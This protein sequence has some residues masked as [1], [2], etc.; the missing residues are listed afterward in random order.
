MKT[1]LSSLALFGFLTSAYAHH[2]FGYHFDAEKEVTIAGT[3]REFKFIN[4]HAQVL[5]D[6]TGEDG[7]TETWTCE[8]RGANGLARTGW[9]E[10]TFLP[11]QALELTG[12]AARRRD[13]ECY[14]DFAVMADG[15][16]I[17]HDDPLGGDLYLASA[18]AAAPTGAASS[19]VP[20]FAGVWGQ[21]PGMGAGADAGMGAGMGMGRGPTLGGPNRFE[22]VLS[23][24]GLRALEEYDPVVDDP[25]IHCKPPS[26]T[27]LWGT[28]NPT[29]I[30]Q[31]DELFTIHH[32]WL[33][34]ERKV[35][36]GLSEHP[37][38]TTD[39]IMGHSIGWYE[40]STLVIDTVAY[41]PSVLFQFPGLPTSNKLHTV[42]RLTLSEDGQNFEISW[43]AE[44][45]EYFTEQ[46]SGASRPLQRLNTTIRPYNC[47]PMEVA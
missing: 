43:M 40:G 5:V 34:V 28:G 33:D 20:N 27:R 39:R 19:D 38:G 36:L 44:D 46:V 21:A 41:E 6:V 24:A 11:G 3:V 7:Q 17:T 1:V 2:S 45:P 12:F 18:D 8:F 29:E 10:D 13:T 9:R 15:S 31:E 23:E 14:F 35:Y 26:L 30:T 16:R 32:E 47:V 4:P 42:E 22:Y 25:S 37:E